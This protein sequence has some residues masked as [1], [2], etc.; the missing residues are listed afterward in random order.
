MFDA[1]KMLLYS[2]DF[3]HWDGDTPDFVVRGFS[4]TF[5]RRVLAE[6]AIELFGL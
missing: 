6:N 3:P 5:K 1:E 4:E 2:S